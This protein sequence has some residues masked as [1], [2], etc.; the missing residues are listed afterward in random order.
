MEIKKLNHFVI[1]LFD[2]QSWS[3]LV[4]AKF[5]GLV[6]EFKLNIN[7]LLQLKNLNYICW[8]RVFFLKNN[9]TCLPPRKEE[10]LLA[11]FIQSLYQILTEI[12][13]WIYN[14]RRKICASLFYVE[15]IFIRL[16]YYLGLELCRPIHFGSRT[17]KCSH[18]VTIINI[19][20]S[21]LKNKTFL[22]YIS[23]IIWNSH[24]PKDVIHFNNILK[25][26]NIQQ[27]TPIWP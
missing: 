5:E 2:V 25:L 20:L 6:Y 4:D 9:A 16:K 24:F 10:F 14:I 21:T 23:S 27:L 19:F 3:Y 7:N 11:C 1:F 13:Y 22:F 17:F 12:F 26:I 18:S 15:V 8:I